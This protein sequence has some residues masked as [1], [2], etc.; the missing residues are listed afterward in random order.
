MIQIEPPITRKTISTPKA[1]AKMLFV[2]SGPLPK[3]RKNTRWTP[4][5]AKASTIN[6]TGMP[7]GPEQIGLRHN[8]GGD[9]CQD[10]EAE[11]HGVGADE[12][13]P[14]RGAEAAFGEN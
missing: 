7:R 12:P 11:A 4:I 10:R 1:R 6:P 2:L 14:L 8:E 5:C 13:Y 9:G 3:C